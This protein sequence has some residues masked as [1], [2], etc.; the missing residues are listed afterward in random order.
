MTEN[1]CT[2]AL[3]VVLGLA[4]IG[5]LKTVSSV[6]SLFST[7]PTAIVKIHSGNHLAYRN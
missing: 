2:A 6:V 3:V 4:A 1:L 7:Q 5:A